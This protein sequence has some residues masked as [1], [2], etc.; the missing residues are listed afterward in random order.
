MVHALV[1]YVGAGSIND[2]TAYGIESITELVNLVSQVSHR[3]QLLSI[4]D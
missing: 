3:F 1:R 2:L 4:I